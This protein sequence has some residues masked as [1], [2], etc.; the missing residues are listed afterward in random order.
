MDL[1]SHRLLGLPLDDDHLALDRL[2]KVAVAA[3]DATSDTERSVRDLFELHL[4]VPARVI[5]DVV[6]RDPLPNLGDRSVHRG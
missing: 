5:P 1:D 6:D 4:R 2:L 3:S